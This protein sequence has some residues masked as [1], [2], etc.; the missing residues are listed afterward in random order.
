MPRW[1]PGRE[2]A[3][4]AAVLLPA[5]LVAQVSTGGLR[6][7]LRSGTEKDELFFPSWIP[8]PCHL[9]KTGF[10]CAL[11]NL[12]G[13]QVVGEVDLVSELLSPACGRHQLQSFQ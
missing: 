7:Y 3:L 10:F 4:A 8:K 13:A 5:A 1:R 9:K 6:L 12:L 2:G 11:F